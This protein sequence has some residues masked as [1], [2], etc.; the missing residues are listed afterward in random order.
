MH[1]IKLPLALA[2]AFLI[3][4]APGCGTPDPA[5]VYKGD[6]FLYHA[7][8]TIVTAYDSLDAFV[9]WEYQNRAALASIPEIRK[10]ADKV[11][12][13]AKDWIDSA[14][15]LRDA[16]LA[17]PTPENKSAFRAALR[18]LRQGLAEAAN[19]MAQNDPT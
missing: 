15:R 5:G 14:I 1:K 8:K 9:L 18:I 2:L 7:E 12:E 11:R 3:A 17:N 16:Y 13:K 10:A 19:H 4:G 6:S